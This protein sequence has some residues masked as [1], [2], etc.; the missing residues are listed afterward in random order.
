MAAHEKTHMREFTLEGVRY[1]TDT[2]WLLAA[3]KKKRIF[4]YRAHNSNYF[5][6]SEGERDSFKLLCIDDAISVYHELPLKFEPSQAN[7]FPSVY[8]G[9]G[10]A[11]P[12]RYDYEEQDV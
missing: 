2:S 5:L 3:D 11:T 10:L 8:G 12:T 7:A 4:L 9:I 6:H 1:R